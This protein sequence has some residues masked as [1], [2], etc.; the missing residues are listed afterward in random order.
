MDRVL[1]GADLWIP[2]QVGLGWQIEQGVQQAAIGNVDRRGFDLM[3]SNVGK[4]GRELPNHQ[5]RGQ[6]IEI[7]PHA[8]GADAEGAGQSAPFGARHI[9]GG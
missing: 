4:P 7:V 5:R 6:H 1:R 2:F 8:W 9:G 3:F